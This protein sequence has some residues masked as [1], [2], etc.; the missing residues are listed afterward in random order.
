MIRRRPP[1]A[2]F[3]LVELLVVI[4]IIGTLMS[5]VLPAVQ[6]TRYAAAR[7]KCQNN[8]KQIGLA[9]HDYHDTLGAFPPGQNTRWSP[10]YYWSWLARILPFIEQDN[11][12][13]EAELWRDSGPP[14]NPRWIPWY[15]AHNT[16]P[17][18]PVLAIVIKTYICPLDD[19]TQT[20]QVAH[21]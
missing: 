17:Q 12:V 11:V 5:L 8:L 6:K 9:L 3:T 14:G 19:V 1:P 2:G 20:A 10:E 18:N 4:A 21:Y 7:T 15:T 16:Q 13:R